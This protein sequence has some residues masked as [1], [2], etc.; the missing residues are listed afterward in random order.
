MGD[1]VNNSSIIIFSLVGLV[2]SACGKPSN[3]QPQIELGK[4][5][6]GH[7]ITGAHDHN[8]DTDQ[9]SSS[10]KEKLRSGRSYVYADDL[11]LSSISAFSTS[12]ILAT[13]DHND[14]AKN[15]LRTTFRKDQMPT[16]EKNQISETARSFIADHYQWYTV[17]YD[18]LRPAPNHI[19]EPNDNMIAV[20]FDR[21]FRG[22]KVDRGLI[23]AFFVRQDER[24]R[25]YE[26]YNTA[27]GRIDLPPPSNNAL[28]KDEIA[29][30]IEEETVTISSST[31]IIHVSQGSSRYQ[32]SYAEKA[33]ITDSDGVTTYNVII[34][35]DDSLILEAWS[36]TYAVNV[37]VS[38]EVPRRSYVTKQMANFP[39]SQV[40]VD[41]QV[42]SNIGNIDID[43]T[44]NTVID[45]SGVANIFDVAVDES[46]TVKIPTTL[47]INQPKTLIT[48]DNVDLAALNT[49]VAMDRLLKYIGKYLTPAQMPGLVQP[50]RVNVNIADTC[51]AFFN[52]SSI[53]FFVAGA[54]GGSDV[55]CGNTALINDVVY[56]E[57]G[58][59][60]DFLT[61]TQ[62]GGSGITDGAFSEGIGDIISS[63]MTR[64]H[65]LAPGFLLNNPNPLRNL[66]NKV[67]HPPQNANE[68]Q[69]H[70]AGQ[71]IGGAFWQTYKLLSKRLGPD[72]A[73]DQIA[74]LFFEQLLTTDRYTDAYAAFLRL[75]D[76]DNDPLTP[77]PNQCAIKKGFSAHNIANGSAA[78]NCTDFDDSIKAR[79][80]GDNDQGSVL[81]EASSYGADALIICSGDV[82]S[83]GRGSDGYQ[84]LAQKE[85]GD[86]DQKII[87][88]ARASL[89]LNQAE[90]YTVVA[91]DDKNQT[92]GRT[93]LN[94]EKQV[95]ED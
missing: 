57:Y 93:V 52:G 54:S 48:K 37:N 77:S 51:N 5:F 1:V 61:G 28:T 80:I 21:Y 14:I 95:S 7:N 87:F 8:A 18:E 22:I 44:I 65:L 59:A 30:I 20:S 58:H 85:D 9:S 72:A 49:Y 23:Q 63:L 17:D 62:V 90:S 27:F 6:K 2:M 45:L 42:T 56:H 35:K 83:C 36:N 19:I 46:D 94:F 68:A 81:I 67:Q 40:G 15:Y 89:D 3:R 39:L 4:I 50:I 75:D 66:D 60:V 71:I 10:F 92:Y 41:N 32:F 29:E 91:L 55:E 73:N 11:G 33:T 12:P 88:K 86:S 38:A 31:P 47:N 26:I 43:Q 78:P 70:Q 74:R 69:V 82:N 84:L 16:V 53:N 64:S 13:I 79:I 25:L 76:D 34:S 24:Y